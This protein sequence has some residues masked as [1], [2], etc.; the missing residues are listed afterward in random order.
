MRYNNT[1]VKDIAVAY[2]TLTNS[3]HY[4]ENREEA[5]LNSVTSFHITNGTRAISFLKNIPQGLREKLSIGEL[6]KKFDKFTH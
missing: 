1:S 5:S 2:A 6:E 4:F 3:L